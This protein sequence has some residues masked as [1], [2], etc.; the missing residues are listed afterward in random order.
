MAKDLAKKLVQKLIETGKYIASVFL[1]W[2]AD[3]LRCYTEDNPPE[4][5]ECPVSRFI[6]WA[7]GYK[8]LNKLRRMR[9]KIWKK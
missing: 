8:V 1:Q 7:F 3:A 5:E 6:A 4:P 2:D 9:A